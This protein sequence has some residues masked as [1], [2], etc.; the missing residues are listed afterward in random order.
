M[1]KVSCLIV[2]YNRKVYLEK[3]VKAV[4]AQTYPITKLLVFDNA[5]SDGTENMMLKLI[6]D[7][8]NKLIFKTELLY[9]RSRYNTGG[10]G[11]FHYGI[12]R[13]L[14]EGCD[15]VWVMDDDVFPEAN[16][17]EELIGHMEE[18]VRMCIPSRTDEKYLDYAITKINMNNPFK[19]SLAAIK[20]RLSS[21][22]VK[23]ETISVVDI[24]FEGPLIDT[25]LIYEIGLPNK[26]LFLQYDD[27]DYAMRASKVTSILF[28]K[29]ALMHKQIIPA[30]SKDRLM[31]WKHY[32][33]YRNQVWFYKQY[34]K[35]CFVRT[36]RPIMRIGDL[37]LRAII[38]RKW[39]NIRI[40]RRAYVDG[41][42][43][44]LGMIIPPEGVVSAKTIADA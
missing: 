39:S 3:T 14:S 25:T 21:D 18:N 37:L 22:D 44:H 16:C 31:N 33:A 36:L 27:T 9:Y 12:K 29:H 13:L 20:T 7:G 2:T 41:I 17:L 30:P 6:K 5:S 35:N 23:E 40:L 19:Y 32:Y 24:S 4:L 1:K 38:L 15:Y 10:S 8:E 34:G 28:C 42:K 26:E 43:G 11:G